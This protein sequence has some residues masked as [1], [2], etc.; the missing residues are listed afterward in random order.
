MSL[1]HSRKWPVPLFSFCILVAGT[2]EAVNCTEVDTYTILRDQ[3]A[4]DTFQAT[5]GPCD[6]VAG[7]LEIRPDLGPT[8]D[9]GPLEDL[10]EVGQFFEVNGSFTDLTGLHN[11]TTVGGG[12]TISGGATP[13][14]DLSGLTSLQSVGGLNLLGLNQLAS[15]SGMPNLTSL[16]GLQLS[17]VPS[18]TNLS[19]LAASAFVVDPPD[20]S[21]IEITFNSDL[22][23]LVGL[24]VGDQIGSLQIESNSG[25]MSLAGLENLVEVWSILRIQD[26][27][28]L[29]DCSVLATVLDAVDDGD[30]GPG[31]GIDPSDPPDTQGLDWITIDGNWPGGGC[32]SIAEILASADFQLIHADGFESGSP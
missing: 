31:D 6:T 25:L 24:P 23:N 11:L 22:P 1:R 12:F 29:S 26:N 4:V 10:V 14:V 5:Y 28:D 9:L 16:G 3:N 18:L 32:N 17:G 21:S 20:E 13:L 15:L 27:D 8:T 7:S 2:A 19:G 30:P